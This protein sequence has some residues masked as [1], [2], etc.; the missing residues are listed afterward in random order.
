MVANLSRQAEDWVGEASQ[1]NLR[2]P[3][4]RTSREGCS[5]TRGPAGTEA[6]VEGPRWAETSGA[7]SGQIRGVQ[8]ALHTPTSCPVF[9]LSHRMSQ[10]KHSGW[11]VRYCTSTPIKR[12]ATETGEPEPVPPNQKPARDGTKSQ[13]RGESA[14]EASTHKVAPRTETKE[15]CKWP[16]NKLGHGSGRGTR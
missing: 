2:G 4:S 14:K 6:Q 16:E 13:A 3:D 8:Q 12:T 10:V 11:L 7:D 1:S 9:C 15:S 5:G